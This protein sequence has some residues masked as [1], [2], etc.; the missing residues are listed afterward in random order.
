MRLVEDHIGIE[1]LRERWP[2]LSRVEQ[3]GRIGDAV[4]E[5]IG[6]KDDTDRRAFQRAFSGVIERFLLTFTDPKWHD[7]AISP[8]GLKEPAIALAVVCDA[9]VGDNEYH[10]DLDSLDRYFMQFALAARAGR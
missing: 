1:G 2:S 8:G 7:R 4:H 3:M 6:A 5:A 10:T 9:L